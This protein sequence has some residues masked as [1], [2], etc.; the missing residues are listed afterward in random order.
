MRAKLFNRVRTAWRDP[1][2]SKVIATAIA[3]VAGAS[4]L[5]VGRLWGE[6]ID[7][8]AS[9]WRYLNST[10]QVQIWVILIMICLSGMSVGTSFCR[11][12]AFLRKRYAPWRSYTSDLIE[13][14]DWR[15]TYDGQGQI[16]DLSAFCPVCN[17]QL[18]PKESTEL[19]FFATRFRCDYCGD[20]SDIVAFKGEAKMDVLDRITRMI[21]RS[22][23]TGDY[24]SV[25]VPRSGQKQ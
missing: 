8:F 9:I 21:H 24:R 16:R 2:L 13:D 22:I 12:A 7:L 6:L 18:R 15:W 20:D 17:Y 10:Q 11:A 4:F 25:I 23:R 5:S 1:V 14:L 19:G 3:A